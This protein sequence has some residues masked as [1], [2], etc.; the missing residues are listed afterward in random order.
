[1]NQ[2]GLR[3]TFAKM[4]SPK[5]LVI[6]DLMLDHY[7]WGEVD[8]ISPEAPIPIMRVLREEHRLGGAGNVAMNLLNLGAKVSVCGAIGKDKNGTII[9]NLLAENGA[10]FSGVISSKNY[11]SCLKHRM[12]AGQNHLLRM[13]IDPDVCDATIQNKLIWFCCFSYF[14]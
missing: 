7:S 11:K 14:I 4:G 8:R 10:D 5:I 2:T 12:I 3:Q 13:D 9:K 6:G 1:M